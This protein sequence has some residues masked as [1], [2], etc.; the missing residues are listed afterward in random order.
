M[1]KGPCPIC[2]ERHK[3]EAEGKGD[4][5][6]AKDLR[7]SKRV[8]VYVVD[9]DD[10][11]EVKAWA[12]S[13]TMDRDF[14]NLSTDKRT[15]EVY[16]I[17]N[18]EE[19]YDVEFTRE[20]KGIQTKYNGVAVARRSSELDNEEA[21]EFAIENPLPDITIIYEYDHIAKAFGT[22]ATAHD[23][24]DKNSSD[25]YTL[26]DLEDMDSDELLDVIDEEELEI[27]KAEKLDEDDLRNAV[28]GEL[29][30]VEKKKKKK[31]KKKRKQ[32]DD[33]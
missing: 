2:E 30:L 26:E 6:Y 19:G 25:S 8:L 5:D 18:P 29:G 27:R 33:E 22:A 11:D 32:L 14:C 24:D 7:T 10:E 13:W 9:R 15:G 3:L 31:E 28:A 21:L 12:M 23:E 16:E 1:N 4:E 20:G 17:D